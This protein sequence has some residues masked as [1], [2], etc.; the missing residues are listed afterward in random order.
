M[1]RQNRRLGRLLAPAAVLLL[2]GAALVPGAGLAGDTPQDLPVA[3]KV[4]EIRGSANTGAPGEKPRS[5]NPGDYVIVGEDIT[6][7]RGS[8]LVLAMPDKT[9][10]EFGGPTTLAF[11]G[12]PD[13][14]GGKVVANLTAAVSD[15]LFG[16]GRQDSEAIMATRAIAAEHRATVPVL[17]CPVPGERLM[18]A[19]D[20]FRWVGIQ[21]V[22]IYR[23][24]VYNSKEMIWQ[25]TTSEGR[26]RRPEMV[27]EFKPDDTYYWAVEALVGDAA[28]RSEA[29]DFVILGEASRLQL[30]DA[31]GYTEEV[32]DPRMAMLIKVR[33][34]MDA[35]AYT[36]A[37]DILD[38]YIAAHPPEHSAYVLRAGLAEKM[39]LMEEAVGYYR[40]AVATPPSE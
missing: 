5:L 9:V 3:A 6:V 13:R 31:I 18:D 20:E 12:D 2:A 19:P 17:T 1:K 15:M 11:G 7:S 37:G 40:L 4:I 35:G 38:D 21:G 29:A 16:S 36:R 23:V 14:T 32:A 24:S 33:L 25:T 34:C 30:E 22:Q 27:C 10:R 26:A 28:L 39:G 8:S